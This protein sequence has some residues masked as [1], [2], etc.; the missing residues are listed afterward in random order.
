MTL[1]PHISHQSRQLLVS[2]GIALT[3][4]FVTFFVLI[5][6]SGF[7]LRAKA[8]KAKTE[9]EI[10]KELRKKTNDDD[11]G[12]SGGQWIS[13]GTRG[14]GYCRPK[15]EDEVR[16]DQSGPLNSTSP[17]PAGGGSTSPSPA[18]GGSTAPS[19]STP[20]S[21]DQWRDFLNGQQ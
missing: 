2:L 15:T 6:Q 16:K 20:Q 19:P 18:A 1:V 7:D 8:K 4:I 5:N 12:N 11:C 3:V 21:M 14:K 17:S 13:T 9:G 10:K